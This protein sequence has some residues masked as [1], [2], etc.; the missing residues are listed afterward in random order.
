M[1]YLVLSVYLTIDET[2]GEDRTEELKVMRN[3]REKLNELPKT[4]VTF[5]EITEVGA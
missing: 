5:I 4:E 2:F 1:E 3:V